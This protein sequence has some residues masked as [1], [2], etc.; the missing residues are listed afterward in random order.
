MAILGQI[1]RRSGVLIGIIALALFAFVIQG[2]IKNSSSLG[3]GNVNLIGEVDGR[4]ISRT[5][6]QKRVAL[7]QK[8]ARNFSQMQAVKAVWDQMVNEAVL[9]N[10]YDNLGISVGQDRIRELIINNPT[11]QQT[12][13]NQQGVFD[14]NSLSQYIEQIYQNKDNNPELYAQWKNFENSLIENEK[15][16]MYLDMLKAAMSPT[17]KEGEWLYHSENDAVDFKYA[18]VPYNTIPDS[19]VTVTKEDIK[20]YINKHQNKY[21]TEE[22]RSI[23]YVFVPLEPSAKDIEKIKD[24]LKALIND[25]E[26]YDKDAP[27]NKKIEKGFKNTDNAEAFV[28]KYSDIKQQARWFFKN[29]LQKEFADTLIKLNKGD[30]FGPYEIRKQIYLSKVLD[31]KMTPDSAKASHILIAY[32][33]ATRAN[34]SVTRDKEAA[35]KR[36][37]SILKVVEKNPKKF[38]DYAKELS[39]GPTKTKGGDLGW[40]TYG[41]MVPTFNDFIFEGEKGKI[42]LVETQFGFHIIKIHELTE[43]EKAIKMISIIRN[44]TP[45]TETENETFAKAAQ[46]AS[47]ALN[48]KTEKDFIEFSKKNNF[49]AKPVKKIGQFEDRLPGLGQARNVISWLYKKDRKVGDVSKFDMEKGHIIAFVTEINKKGLMSPEEASVLVK[50]ILIKE[51]KAE[52]IKEKF[53]G[54]NFDEMAKNANARVGTA[55]GVSLKNPI[56]P[57]FGKEPVVVAKA[58]SLEPG[59]YSQPIEGTKAVYIVQTIKVDKVADIKN[60]LPYVLKLKKERVKGLEKDVINALKEKAKIEDNRMNIYN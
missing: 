9:N 43:P 18:A 36:A 56:I 33:G 12:F 4:K 22:N 40:F 41:Q 11:I 46:F 50:P 26:V 6:F 54:S 34:P 17:L 58:F 60:Y 23:S 21:K 14:E 52:I 13:T 39:D 24:E 35:K 2:L 28:N 57:G 37:D 7:M 44:V 27:D 5:D 29:K 8:Q 15:K 1:Q 38:A 31:T 3:K 51:K 32:K 55:T 30:I 20:A 59:K 48:A 19:L 45:S 53:K 49:E 47:D 25:K 10:E 42:G 16:K